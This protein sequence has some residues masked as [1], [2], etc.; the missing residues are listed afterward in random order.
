METDR[1]GLAPLVSKTANTPLGP[2]GRPM[3]SVQGGRRTF[4]PARVAELSRMYG[5]QSVQNALHAPIGKAAGFLPDYDPE[6]PY[7][8]RMKQW[9]AAGGTLGAIGHGLGG[10]DAEWRGSGRNNMDAASRGWHD[11]TYS[12]GERALSALTYGGMMGGIGGAGGALASLPFGLIHG[13]ISSNREHK[14]KI[15]ELTAKLQPNS[16]EKQAVEDA[17][18]R[19]KIAGG[20][21]SIMGNGMQAAGNWLE[22][23]PQMGLKGYGA[24]RSA[25]RPGVVGAGIGAIGGF[26]GGGE[27]HRLSGALKGGLAGGAAGA[28]LGG[29][30]GWK[31]VGNALQNKP[32]L[33][34][35]MVRGMAQTGRNIA[36]QGQSMMQQG[37]RVLS[38]G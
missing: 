26:A 19:Y 37:Q 10:V 13:A 11:L 38:S 33:M 30:Q 32:G 8:S 9:A 29:Y 25:L 24:A 36:Q 18:V 3:I 12:P 5:N 4:D 16:V 35:P 6:H 20:F 28:G 21:G 22:K 7:K 15:D 31:R 34:Q 2:D 27:D 14:K 17:C 23:N 1:Y